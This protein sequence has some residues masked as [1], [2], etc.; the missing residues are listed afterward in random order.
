MA[1]GDRNGVVLII[2]AVLLPVLVGLGSLVLED[3]AQAERNRAADEELRAEMRQIHQE[4][5]ELNRRVTI[6]A[7]EDGMRH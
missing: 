1:E 5:Q 2:A 6:D 4:L 7:C 3:R